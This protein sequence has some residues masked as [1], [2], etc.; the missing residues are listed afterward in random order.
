MLETPAEMIV[1]GAVVKTLSSRYL[2]GPP[3]EDEDD[4][5]MMVAAH[6]GAVIMPV[7]TRLN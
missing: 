3:A 2:L 1:E 5:A 7:R 6:D 4:K